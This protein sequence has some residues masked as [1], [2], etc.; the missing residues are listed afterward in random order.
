LYRGIRNGQKSSFWLAAFI[1][2]CIMYISPF[3]LGYAGWYGRYPYRTIMFFVP[4]QQLFL[5]PPLLY[6]YVKSLLQPSF[7]FQRK[8]WLHFIPA[9]LYAIYSLIVWITDILILF[10]RRSTR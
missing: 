6:F 5:M 10:L 7:K 2:L 9:I 8:D 4:F 3:M 1:F